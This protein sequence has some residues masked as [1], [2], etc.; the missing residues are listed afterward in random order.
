M[1]KV[2]KTPETRNA[3][4]AGGEGLTAKGQTDL[5]ST[6][7]KTFT[8]GNYREA[9]ALFEQAAGGPSMSVSES[10]RMYRRMCLQRME[11]EEPKLQSAEDYYNA[12]VGLFNA[13]R[14]QEARAHLE[15]AASQ[16]P[17]PHYL[18]ALALAEGMLGAVGKAAQ[19]LQKAMQAD[20]GI[21]SV[22]RNDADFAPLME[23]A[24][25]REILSGE[26]T[27]K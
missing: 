6:A 15:T 21:R 23:H 9:A 22:A 20:P 12:G 3:A 14:Y 1:K 13:R 2:P 24:A 17:M 7:V 18:Y 26:H 4:S 5:F 11:S 25:I 10:A 8:S 19:Q 27:T 16:S